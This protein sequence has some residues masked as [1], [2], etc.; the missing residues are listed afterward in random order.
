MRKGLS[1]AFTLYGVIAA[2]SGSSIATAQT[3][4]KAPVNSQ[5]DLPRH[6]YPMN[7]PASTFVTVDDAAFRSFA[8]SVLADVNSTLEDY[9]IKDRAT[10]RDELASKLILQDLVGDNEA[11]LVT[12]RSLRENQDKP[13]ARLTTGLEEEAILK[14]RIL[15][16]A[17]TGPVYQEAVGRIYSGLVDALPWAVVADAIKEKESRLEIETSGLVLATL[18]R[19]I[20]PTVLQAASVSDEG[21][22]AIANSRHFMRVVEPLQ[23]QLLAALKTFITANNVEKP[24]IWA[25]REVTLSPRQHLTPVLVGIWDSGVDTSLYTAQLYNDPH[26]GDHSPHGLA[27]D[28][29]GNISTSDLQPMTD[30]QRQGYPQILS[31]FQ[32]FDDL[33]NQID[34]PDAAAVREWSSSTPPDQ[35]PEMLKLLDFSGN[36]AHGTHVAGIAARGNPA[37]RLV[38]ARF[39]DNL[40]EY[41]FPPTIQWANRFATDFKLLGDYFRDHH[42]RVVNMSWGDEV[43]EFETWLSKTSPQ[44]DPA[45]RKTEAT[46]IYQVWR[47]GIEHAI[48]S[49][50]ATLFVVAAGNTDSNAGFLGDVPASLHLSNMISVGAV[51]Q[52]GE[53]TTFTSY[54]DTVV[55]D[56]AGYRVESFVPGGRTMRFSGTSMAS[57][58]VVNL[59]AKLFALDPALTPE[60][61][62]ALIRQG[63]D[64]SADGRLHV[65]NPKATVALL[66]VRH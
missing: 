22:E 37:V 60:Q 7:R 39:N 12:L 42:V 35:L 40:P 54:G 49:A 5:T 66:P 3:A 29:E 19:E 48:R 10:L 64:A 27:F 51:N 13:S 6:S 50:P 28:D 1:L 38:V 47:A 59:A 34:S 25:A 63:A 24:D 30:E 36:F 53:A 65:I 41:P 31:L 33:Q 8:E 45:K 4:M 18:R 17:S 20:D 21:A 26:P 23:P 58:N 46:A 15:S 9:D 14:A 61:V 57:P 44:N 11:G 55:V 52:A 56:A 32:G 2:A 16:K 43:S 62:V